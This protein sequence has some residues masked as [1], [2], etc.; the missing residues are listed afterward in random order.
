VGLL[1]LLDLLDV[2]LLV[3]WF[4]VSVLVIVYVD[5]ESRRRK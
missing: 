1:G 3:V 4:I 5:S 2:D